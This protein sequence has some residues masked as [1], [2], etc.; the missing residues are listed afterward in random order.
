VENH[1]FPQ[2]Y[3]KAAKHEGEEVELYPGVRS[4]SR[5]QPWWIFHYQH[6]RIRIFLD[7]NTEKSNNL[8]MKEIFSVLPTLLSILSYINPVLKTDGDGNLTL[9]QISV[10][11]QPKNKTLNSQLDTISFTLYTRLELFYINLLLCGRSLCTCCIFCVFE[12]SRGT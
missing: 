9:L 4:E 11:P 5:R 2:T 8:V 6:V 12:L 7:R 3:K 10:T 1:C